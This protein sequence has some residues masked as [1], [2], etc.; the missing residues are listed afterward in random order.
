MYRTRR[1]DATSTRATTYLKV[2]PKGVFSSLVKLNITSGAVVFSNIWHARH[3]HEHHH[4]AVHSSRRAMSRDEARYSDTNKFI[5]GRFLD[6][7]GMLTDDDPADFVFG[8]GRRICSGWSPMPE[9]KQSAHI[10]T[11]SSLSGRYV[12]DASVWS[13][14]VTMLATL[15]FNLAKDADG[16]DITF[17]ATFVNGATQ[18]V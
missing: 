18:H 15:N 8:F 3:T 2:C 9:H 11:P 1:R 7:N 12:A 5:P 10:Q 14:M 17:T 16:N 4:G 6:A 13:A